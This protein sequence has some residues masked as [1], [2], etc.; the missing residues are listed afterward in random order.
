MR[1]RPVRTSWPACI[2]LAF[3]LHPPFSSLSAWQDAAKTPRVVSLAFEGH[4][5]VDEASL[6]KVFRH[7]RE[8]GVYSAEAL[9]FDAGR[10]EEY[11]RDQGYLRVSV[12]ECPVEERPQPD[13]TTAVAI[14]VPISEG[15]RYLL[16]SLEVRGAE[17]LSS[18]SLLQMAPLR[19][20]EPFSRR[21]LEEW[22]A[23][24]AE[25]YQSMGYLRF[26]GELN[27]KDD[28]LRHTVA[29]ELACTE[30]DVYRVRKISVIGDE[31][32]DVTEF[33]RKILVGEGGVYNPEMVILTLQLLN[34]LRIYKPLTQSDVKIRIDD[35]A[36]AVDVE[37]RVESRQAPSIVR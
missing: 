20:G 2:L 15:P 12:G 21:R 29:V 22:R 25:S 16:K 19:T 36:H 18:E 35:D 6:R 24:I 26:R 28:D 13:G 34:E 32:V 33:R 23:K 27:Q 11:Y 5:S 8:G 7:V 14:R 17:S 30:G 9:R 3:T 31:S 37:F 4:S 10:L 1:F